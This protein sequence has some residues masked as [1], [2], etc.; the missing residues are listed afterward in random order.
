MKIWNLMTKYDDAIEFIYTI[1]DKYYFSESQC[2]W[3]L[4]DETNIE[5]I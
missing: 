1:E 5:I 3:M 4:T 2:S